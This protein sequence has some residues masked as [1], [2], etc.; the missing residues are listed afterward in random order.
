MVEVAHRTIEANGL[1]I[2]YA[3][4]AKGRLCCSATVFPSPG[5]PGAIN[6]RR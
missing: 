2:H 4:R 3:R 6:C 1:K 5:T